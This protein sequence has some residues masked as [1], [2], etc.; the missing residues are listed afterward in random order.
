MTMFVDGLSGLV[1]FF[2]A[3]LLAKA[4]LTLLMTL[5]AVR[6]ARRSRASVRHLLLVAGFGVLLVLPI[7]IVLVPSVRVEVAPVPVM[8]E[9]YLAASMPLDDLAPIDATPIQT[10][11]SK[12]VHWRNVATVELLIAIWIGGVLLCGIPLFIG[13]VQVRRLRRTGLPWRGGQRLVDAL[14]R[15]AGVPQPIDV[16][17]HESVAAPATCGIS[18]H[19]VLFPIDADRWTD[20]DILRAAVHEVEHI[21][22][23]DCLVNAVARTIC[24]AYWFHPLVWVAWRRLGLEAERA[25]DDAVLRRGDADAYADQLVTLAGRLSAST[26]H[27]LLAMA[28]RSDLVQRVKA[29]LDQH[30]ARGHAGVAPGVTIAIAASALIVTLSPL[31]AVTRASATTA[32][33]QSPVAGAVPQFEVA[34]IRINRSGEP[35]ARHTIVPASGR[36]T[37]TNISVSALI[38]EAYGVPLVLASQL[39]N[40]MPDWAR[41]MRV[42]VVAKAASPTPVATLQRMLQPL[43]AEY[44]KLA[45]R[46]EPRDMDVFAMVVAN[47]GRLGPQLRR[48]DDACDDTVGAADGFARAPEGAP[49]QKGTCGILPG[50]AGRIVARALDM[51]GLAA[52]IGT[53]PGRMVIDRTG[54]TG[55]FDIDLTYTPSL[56]TAEALAQRP[57]AAPPPGVDPSGP[58]LITAL[59]EQL[60]LRLDPVRAPVEVLVIEHADPLSADETAAGGAAPAAQGS[61]PAF[62]V[63]SIRRNVEGGVPRMRVEAGR[64]VASNT[65]LQELIRDAYRMQSFQVVGGPEWWR[66]AGGPTRAAPASQRPGEVTFDVIA[67]IPPNTPPAQVPLMLRTLLAD[68]FSLVVHT[69][70]REMP[71]YVLTYAR[72]DKTLGPQLTRSTQQCQAEIDGGP[73]RAPVTRVS[74]DGKPVCGM[75][76]GPARIRGGGLTT[77]VLANALTGYVQRMVVDRTGLEGPIDFDL[78]YAPAARGGGPAPSDDRPSIFTTV[79]EQLGLKLEAA[80]APVEVLIVDSVSMPTE[81]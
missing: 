77:S 5:G 47:P 16:L 61:L 69:E 79:Q 51:P 75:M 4:T 29:V 45:V 19:A 23:A 3:S 21:R 57:G 34:T 27:P 46:R 50:G 30:Q 65:S 40:N 31:Q 41:T 56:F 13:M 37:I 68:R 67:N 12:S 48:N 2:G 66:A 73:L 59:R 32:A 74:E 6:L 28:N 15:E 49:N 14:A 20:E 26:R 42:D 78:T 39:V 7:A 62:E 63:A 24:A 53:A 80:T 64:F 60:G 35:R 58:P 70:M 10:S 11:V 43:L 25:C 52:F 54:I 36:L 9:E 1:A 71:V 33:D 44:F 81:N 18:R 38:Q 55:R 76:M 22:R 17:L 72:D 8:F